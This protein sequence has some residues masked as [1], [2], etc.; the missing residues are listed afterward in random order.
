MKCWCIVSKM[1]LVNETLNVWL[2][3]FQI[4]PLI[5]GDR[6]VA[7]ISYESDVDLY[8]VKSCIKKLMS[9]GPRFLHNNLYCTINCNII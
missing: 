6:H 4:I 9:V 2:N 8:I 1:C 5:D 7:R 3:I